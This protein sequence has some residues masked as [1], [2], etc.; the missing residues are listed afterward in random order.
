MN[1]QDIMLSEISQTPKGQICMIPLI[2]DIKSSQSHENRKYNGGMVVA[3]QQVKGHVE[4]CSMGIVSVLQHEQVLETHY[5][6]K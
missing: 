5:T 2:R 6:T 3:R 4:S 1:F